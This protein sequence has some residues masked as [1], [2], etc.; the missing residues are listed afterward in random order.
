MVYTIYHAVAG[1]FNPE[2]MATVIGAQLVAISPPQTA[3]S[4]A[5]SRA[6]ELPRTTEQS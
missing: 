1:D 6:L 5:D 4:L 2:E 3:V